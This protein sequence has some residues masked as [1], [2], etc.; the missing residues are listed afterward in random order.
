MRNTWWFEWL[1]RRGMYFAPCRDNRV[2]SLILGKHPDYEKF[3]AKPYTV[4]TVHEVYRTECDS[5]PPVFF[6][7]NNR[8]G[9][10]L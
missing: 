3:E 9:L 4:H 7:P 2:P 1:P 10:S 8:S 5:V 6:L